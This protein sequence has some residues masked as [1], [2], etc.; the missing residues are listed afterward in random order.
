MPQANGQLT[1]NLFFINLT[2]DLTLQLNPAQVVTG[3]RPLGQAPRLLGLDCRASL[4]V[5]DSKTLSTI[6]KIIF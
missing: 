1:E 6:P 2:F 4:K 3:T 5:L